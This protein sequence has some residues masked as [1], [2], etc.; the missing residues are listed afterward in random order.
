MGFGSFDHTVSREEILKQNRL[1]TVND[2]DTGVAAII[3]AVLT[4]TMERIIATKLRARRIDP[5]RLHFFLKAVRMS[6]EFPRS[7]ATR[8]RTKGRL[9]WTVGNELVF[10]PLAGV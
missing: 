9:G 8:A 7:P 5:A 1:A 6:V 3:Q 10:D 2:I 4:K